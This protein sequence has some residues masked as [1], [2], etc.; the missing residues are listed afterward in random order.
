M[1]KSRNWKRQELA[2]V[3]RRLGAIICRAKKAENELRRLGVIPV[4][5]TAFRKQMLDLIE[6]IKRHFPNGEAEWLLSKCEETEGQMKWLEAREVVITAGIAMYTRT[7]ENERAELLATRQ[8]DLA[9]KE[10]RERDQEEQAAEKGRLREQR[11]KA[12]AEATAAASKRTPVGK[13]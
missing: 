9:A 3:R 8:R 13:S 6:R 7:G 10:Q 2:K 11:E 12:A 5:Y 1:R 4:G